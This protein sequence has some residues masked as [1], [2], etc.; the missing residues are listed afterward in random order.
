MET[1]GVLENAVPRGSSSRRQEWVRFG[2]HAARTEAPPVRRT[3]AGDQIVIP[4]ASYS[5]PG[6]DRTR[7]PADVLQRHDTASIAVKCCT[8]YPF[9]AYDARLAPSSPPFCVY[10]TT[11]LKPLDDASIFFKFSRSVIG[12]YS[13]SPAADPTPKSRLLAPKPF[14]A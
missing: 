11:T 7:E 5:L 2:F 10:M 13:Q 1:R 14:G 8:R 9:S 12:S 6:A 3:H 4:P